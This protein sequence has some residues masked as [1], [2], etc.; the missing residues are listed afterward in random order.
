MYIYLICFSPLVSIQNSFLSLLKNYIFGLIPF[1]QSA[2][3]VAFYSHLCFCGG[4]AFYLI[5]YNVFQPSMKID[6]SAILAILVDLLKVH[7]A[8]TLVSAV[9]ITTVFSYM[10]CNK[11]RLKPDSH[12]SASQG[13]VT[14]R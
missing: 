7:V 5:L 8:V 3:H 11:V 2:I 14:V 13:P 10:L 4:I 6:K 12:Y 1:L 9:F